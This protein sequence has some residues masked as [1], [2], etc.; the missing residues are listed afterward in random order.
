MKESKQKKKE[1][2][3]LSTTLEFDSSL[4]C[5]LQKL[6]KKHFPCISYF[7]K[8]VSLVIGLLVFS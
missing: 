8:N 7:F 2:N 4:G 3:S 1:S 6:L 5:W